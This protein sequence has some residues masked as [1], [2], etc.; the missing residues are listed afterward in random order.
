M[1]CRASLLTFHMKLF[2]SV[3]FFQWYNDFRYLSEKENR[4]NIKQG[5]K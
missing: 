4:F 1:N 2:L 5:I 3:C